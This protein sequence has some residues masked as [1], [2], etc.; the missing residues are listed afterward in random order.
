MNRLRI[1]FLRRP[2]A[3]LSALVLFG[4]VTVMLPGYGIA[5]EPEPEVVKAEETEELATVDSVQDN[6][7]VL[8]DSVVPLNSSV[9]L[10]DRYGNRTEQSSFKVGDQVIVTSVEDDAA[11][12]QRIV[13]IRLKK[14][15]GKNSTSSERPATKPNHV[16]KKVD[17]VWT[18]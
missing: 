2:A 6:A 8:S 3:V 10:Y 16:I 11:G 1:F 13:S 17:G 4:I 14:S 5:E 9:L 7:F 15:T 12:E 18:N